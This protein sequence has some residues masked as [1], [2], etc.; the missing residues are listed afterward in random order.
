MCPNPMR[1]LRPRSRR[2]NAFCTVLDHPARIVGSLFDAG[3]RYFDEKCAAFERWVSEGS[4]IPFDKSLAIAYLD[5]TRG[6]LSKRQIKEGEPVL[7]TSAEKQLH[8]E[9]IALEDQRIVSVAGI[10][11]DLNAP[12]YDTVAEHVALAVYL[13]LARARNDTGGYGPWID[14]L[15]PPHEF[16]N[17]TI[18]WSNEELLRMKGSRALTWSLHA[19]QL[20]EEVYRRLC[21]EAPEWF[22]AKD[23]KARR[24]FEH[25]MLLVD[26]R[27]FAASP[28]RPY[29]VVMAPGADMLSHECTAF[30]A[31]A[32]FCTLSDGGFAVLATR[33]IA[34]GEP[35]TAC[36]GEFPNAQLLVDGGFVVKG[37]VH[38]SVDVELGVADVDP[39]LPDKRLAMVEAGF[40]AEDMSGL[41]ELR[42]GGRLPSRMLEFARI[43]VASSSSGIAAAARR[44]RGGAGA[45]SMEE[46]LVKESVARV[47]S[48]RLGT[49]DEAVGTDSDPW[50]RPAPQAE[51]GEPESN[52]DRRRRLAS[53]LVQGE[54]AILQEAL[55]ALR[56]PRARLRDLADPDSGV[57]AHS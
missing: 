41:F 26:S 42:A 12:L 34:K 39:L 8:V 1:A 56:K 38:D 52:E 3:T 29:R 18:Y 19:K 4:P 51:G 6:C 24:A 27:C 44:A 11:R 47:L 35:V 32:E 55:D 23:R 31:N 57:V 10:M 53:V 13:Y 25:A 30:G 20:Y 5:G 33:D 43:A 37:N 14:F 50:A 48:E 17:A 49:Y 28:S 36:Y 16:D 15:P 21:E 45:D 2:A 54:R 7:F 46:Q 40:T 22:I 9:S